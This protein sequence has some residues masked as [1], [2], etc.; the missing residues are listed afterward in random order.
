M[1]TIVV[2]L[3]GM[4]MFTGCL[5]VTTT[6]EIRPIGIGRE[7]TSDAASKTY[8]DLAKLCENRKSTFWRLPVEEQDTVARLVFAN[9]YNANH[10]QYIGLS[11]L[12]GEPF[13]IEMFLH[14]DDGLRYLYLFRDQEKKWY[15]SSIGE[16]NADPGDL[17][18]R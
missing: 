14:D 9:T 16:I 12:G 1:R 11:L 7:M 10:I 4:I 8:R 18:R 17:I 13:E 2:G 5:S 6:H 3:W 15:L